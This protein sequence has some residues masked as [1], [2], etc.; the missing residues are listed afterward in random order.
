LKY[1]C[2]GQMPYEVIKNMPRVQLTVQFGSQL[3]Q[4]DAPMLARGDLVKQMIFESYDIPPDRQ[5][6]WLPNNIQLPADHVVVPAA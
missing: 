1:I 2:N 3:L 5:R 4:Y 6:L